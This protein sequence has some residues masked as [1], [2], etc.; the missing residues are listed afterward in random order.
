MNNQ[1][2]ALIEFTI[3][4]NSAVLNSVWCMVEPSDSRVVTPPGTN[5][6]NVCSMACSSNWSLDWTIGGGIMKN[7]ILFVRRKCERSPLRSARTFVSLCNVLF[8]SN[9]WCSCISW[10][11]HCGQCWIYLGFQVDQCVVTFVREFKSFLSQS[12]IKINLVLITLVHQ[13]ARLKHWIRLW[14]SDSSNMQQLQFKLIRAKHQQ[15]NIHS[16]FNHLDLR[17]NTDN[18]WVYYCLDAS[19]LHLS[20]LDDHRYVSNKIFQK[21]TCNVNNNGR[22]PVIMWIVSD[23]SNDNN[24]QQKRVNWTVRVAVWS[25]QMSI[26]IPDFDWP[27]GW[28]DISSTIMCRIGLARERSSKYEILSQWEINQ[29]FVESMKS[30]VRGRVF[31][32][33]GNQLPTR[34]W[35]W[36]DVDTPSSKSID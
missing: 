24:N 6:F 16:F 5:K 28:W 9:G 10:W 35:A 30:Y 27:N 2:C 1:S 3:F 36:V 12:T 18:D 15:L 31:D 7:K 26:I 22:Y 29:I 11:Y 34:E 17:N 21:T 25:G 13:F 20:H 32:E 23:R 8:F 14:R 4:V 19:H 33:F